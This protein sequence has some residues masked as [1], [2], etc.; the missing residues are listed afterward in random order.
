MNS[1]LKYPRTPHLQGSR[2]Q[3]G[4]E[5]MEGVPWE[6]LIGRHLVVEEKLDGANVGL[7]LDED[8]QLHLQSRGHFLTGGHRERHFNLFKTW[9]HSHQRSF[10]ER[11]GDR[12]QLA[13]RFVQECRGQRRQHGDPGRRTI[14]RNGTLRYM[15]MD[16]CLVEH[17]RV[18]PILLTV[19]FQ[20]T[21][22]RHS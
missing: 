5:D 4:D 3:P 11:L 8:G 1:I 19:R 6:S 12:Y 9:A 22:C 7:S 13:Q 20:I 2:S 15:D 16:I 21:E 10:W 14:F 17:F 18:D